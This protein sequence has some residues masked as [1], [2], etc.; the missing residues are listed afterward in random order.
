MDGNGDFQPFSIS[1]F[2]IIQ[3]KQAFINGWPWGSGYIYICIRW[4]PQI[5]NLLT[6]MVMY[7][8]A[9]TMAESLKIGQ[10]ETNS[11][12]IDQRSKN[13]LTK[14]LIFDGEKCHGRKYEQKSPYPV[15]FHDFFLYKRLAFHP[16]REFSPV[17]HHQLS[18]EKTPMLHSTMSNNDPYPNAPDLP[19]WIYIE[20]IIIFGIAAH[21][22]R[23]GYKNG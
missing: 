2:G 15:P 7:T 4:S 11:P 10:K 20:F 6:Q 12:W 18:H 14:S 3:L 22:A 19:A 9:F 21:L 13:S 17:V 5:S 23:T 16:L 8:F 1:R